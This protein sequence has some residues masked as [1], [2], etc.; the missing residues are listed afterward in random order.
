MANPN[1][2]AAL[3]DAFTRAHY[4]VPELGDS[5]RVHVGAEATALEARLP[6]ATYGFITA[7]NPD[8]QSASPI[9]NDR[10][11]GELA[12]ELDRLGTRRLRAHAQDD[13]GGHREDGWLVLDL[14]LQGMDRL[15]RQFGQD[16]VLAWEAGNP[17]RLRL[18]HREPADAA[19][20]LWIDW[21]G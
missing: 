15:A 13:H 6:G 7:W 20:R 1:D 19:D 2:T 12:A 16:G 11:D 10:A 18:Y 8:S 17:V 4:L 14:P 21:V 3:A 5:A 9:D